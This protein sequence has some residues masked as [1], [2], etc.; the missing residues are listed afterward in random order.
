MVNSRNIP[1]RNNVRS[2]YSTGDVTGS[3]KKGININRATQSNSQNINIRDMPSSNSLKINRG[4][5]GSL[6]IKPTMGMQ[7]SN[8]KVLI[9]ISSPNFQTPNDADHEEIINSLR[10]NYMNDFFKINKG[11]NNGCSKPDDEAVIDDDYR[12]IDAQSATLNKEMSVEETFDAAIGSVGGDITREIYKLAAGNGRSDSISSHIKFGN[13]TNNNNNTNSNVS[14]HSGND[15]NSLKHKKSL[16]LEDIRLSD[17][18]SRR[19]SVA[20][21]LQVPGGFRREYIVNKRRNYDSIRG[22]SSSNLNSYNNAVER[23]NE[24]E[25][26][27]IP[28]LTRNFMEFL[29]IYGHFAGESFEDDFIEPEEGSLEQEG[30]IEDLETGQLL[31]PIRNEQILN[32]AKGK[33]STKKAFFLLLKSFIGTG[34]LFLPNAFSKG[35]L[36]FSNVLI[37]IFGFYSYYCYMLLIKCKRYSQVSS[38]GEM[39]NKLYGPLMQKIILF[40]IMISQIGFSCAYII[41]TSTNL[42]YFF[43]QYPLTEK[44][45]FNFFLIFQLI[46]FIPLSFV[47]NISKL[48]VPSLVAN[49]MIIIGLMIVIYYCVKQFTVDMGFHMANGVEI[50]FNRQDWSI[51]VGTAIFAFEGIGLLIPIEES[52][53]KPEEFGKVLG[54]VIGCVTSLFILIGSMGYVTYGEDINTVILINLPNDK[55]TVQSI[56]LLYSI[57]IMLSIPLQIFPAIKIIENF[58]INYGVSGGDYRRSGKYNVYYKWLKNCLRSIIIV[59]IIL[60]SKEFINQLDKFVSIIGSVACIPLVYIY[61]SLLHLRCGGNK[62]RNWVMILLGLAVMVFTTMF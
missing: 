30:N 33:T 14:I 58:I 61:P 22:N 44:L 23:R 57:A 17:E 53:A 2:G 48:S 60:I 49:L 8:S 10:T 62:F 15:V 35:G 12:S 43:Q 52:M 34:I 18:R 25:S 16:V 32:R 47:R 20:G 46:L 36:I 45:D 27:T 1:N 55:V 37:I 41:F 24:E 6:K 11:V 21:G 38:F 28:F 56:Q 59:I 29:Y 40:S 4:L 5:S 9:D 50:F 13:N 19:K 3:P 54:G 31:I 26:E 51:F 39:G 7:I 42:N